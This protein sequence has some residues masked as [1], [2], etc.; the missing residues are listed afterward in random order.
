MPS[1][2]ER[3][4]Q[5][6]AAKKLASVAKEEIAISGV[7]SSLVRNGDN[8]MTTLLSQQQPP[9]AYRVSGAG[10]EF[11][12]GLYELDEEC[13]GSGGHINSDVG[14]QYHYVVP[15]NASSGVGKTLTLFQ[16]TMR[17]RVKWWFI[18]EAD[19]DQP[20]T[21]RDID[22]YQHKSVS[23][24]EA[25]PTSSDWI[26]SSD[27]ADPPP[28]LEAVGLKYVTPK[29]L[30]VDILPD[31]LNFLG[32]C[33]D[34]TF[35]QVM[36]SVDK[37]DLVCPSMWIKFLW[38]A[39]TESE[40]F[41]LQIAQNIGPL[42][43]CMCADTKRMFF[44]SNRYWRKAIW[45]FAELIFCL[46]GGGTSMKENSSE[47]LNTVVEALLQHEGLLTTIVQWGFWNRKVRPDIIK[48]LQDAELQ[49]IRVL[50]S[51]ITQYLI[52]VIYDGESEDAISLS[53]GNLNLV[54]TIGSAPVVS[55][56]Y[57]PSCMV[58]FVAEKIQ[59]LKA[60]GWTDGFATMFQLLIR[61]ADC[62]DEG[63]IKEVIDLGINSSNYATALFVG[64]LSSS[65]LVRT[66]N[67]V[68]KR[69][70]QGDHQTSDTRV[71]LAIRSGLIEMCQG[72]IRQYGWHESFTDEICLSLSDYLGR[73][74]DIVHSTSFQKKSWKAIRHKKMA[75]K[76][77]LELTVNTI[78]VRYSAERT[79][80]LKMVRFFLNVNGS[81]CCRCNKSLSRT[82]VK[83]CNGCGCMTYCSRACQKEDWLNGHKLSCGKTYTNETVGQFQGRVQPEEVPS[84]DRDASNLNDFVLNVNMIG[85][86]LFKDN[87]DFILQQARS[88]G[89][90]LC[91]CI[92]VFDMDSCPCTLTTYSYSKFYN[93]ELKKL[94]E[95]SRSEK[96]ITC[97]YYKHLLDGEAGV[98]RLFPHEWLLVNQSGQPIC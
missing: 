31:I 86:K 87:S 66:R 3:G 9:Q 45:P 43:S 62:V 55:K 60:T 56:E 36:A 92:V 40:S 1:K 58:S 15:Y 52:K 21:E 39:A 90:P 18:S 46:V 48:E 47:G 35:R 14:V 32:R 13:I 28:K 33:E 10:T 70:L 95:D 71:A 65:M 34:E 69:P 42:V 20:G 74:F 93:T 97:R 76:L 25:F 67:V 91:D 29:S 7:S 80:L 85:L 41:R 94:Y 79:E 57:D 54:Q 49:Q 82:E 37:G 2:R 6:K 68:K 51:S 44:K 59:T 53:E 17:S 8:H 30:Y 83:L 38:R 19:S 50:G 88:L 12:N 96:N 98:Q 75:I 73:L 84:N 61:H 11:V 22:Y 26:L 78:D 23:L 4:K 89:V 24:L 63:V 64:E 27:G 72:F 81:Y 16:C 5:R 77:E